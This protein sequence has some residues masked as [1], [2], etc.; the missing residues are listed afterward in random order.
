MNVTDS[1]NTEFYNDPSKEIVFKGPERQLSQSDSYCGFLHEH[2]TSCTKLQ[3]I[4]LFHNRDSGIQYICLCPC[5]SNWFKVG[6]AQLEKDDVMYFHAPTRV[7]QH[8]N[9]NVTTV[10]GGILLTLPVL[11]IKSDQTTTTQC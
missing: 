5:C 4:W 3:L 10:R 1:R 11:S 6:G 7:E 8:L 2:K 9:Q